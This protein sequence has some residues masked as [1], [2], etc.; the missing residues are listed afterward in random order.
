MRWHRHRVWKAWDSCDLT[1]V[2]PR[3]KDGGEYNT[4]EKLANS[5]LQ[6]WLNIRT[7]QHLKLLINIKQYSNKRKHYFNDVLIQT[8]K[9]KQSFHMFTILAITIYLNSLS[10]PVTPMSI[11]CHKQVILPLLPTCYVHIKGLSQANKPSNHLPNRW[12]HEQL[13]S[14][15]STALIFILWTII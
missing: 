10:W 7:K 5:I 4:P 3:A 9:T 12:K 13:Q 11:N 2:R 8:V 6:N 1:T 14:I 15:V